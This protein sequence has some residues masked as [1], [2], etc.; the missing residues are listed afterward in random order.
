MNILV[1][2]SG[3]S[4]IKFKLYDMDNESVIC[5]GLIEQIGASNSYAKLTMEKTNKV[6][7]KKEPVSDHY[8][9]INIMNELFSKSGAL[10]S[11]DE[12]DAVGHRVVQGADYF[13]DATLVNEDVL[14]KIEHLIPLAPLH[15]PANLAG[16]KG[17]LK[18][19]PNMPNVVVFDTVFHQ[20]MPKNVYMYP[21]PLEFYEKYKVRKYG[22]HGTSH[23]FVAKTCS[24]LIGVDFDKLN[25]ITLHLGNG[26]SITAIKN[27]KC[28]DTT[29]GLTPLEGL[30][31]GTRCGDIDPAIIPF[32]VKNANL[33][34][35]ELDGIMNKKSGLLAI[36]GTNDMRLIESKMDSGDKNA[37]LAFEMFVLRIKKYIG[38]YVAILSEVNAIVFTAGI[39]ENDFRIRQAVCEGL[40]PIGI[41]IDK[42]KNSILGN[43]PRII[44]LEDSKIKI[45]VVPTDEELAIAKDTV[46]I[47][48]KHKK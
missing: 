13:N 33:S 3:S 48:A 42:E 25:C 20:S 9:G 11:L 2:N 34:A 43:K 36:G 8:V 7:D 29:M 39:G 21:L 24:K 28:V 12:V 31:M 40:E 44:S 35:E 15:N 41:K 14:E 38:A 17:I 5:K 46:R 47:L 23:E 19:R 18:V 16:I 26:A 45:T 22:A 4:S 37:K 10:K 32:L 6:F 1:I 27:G 30:M